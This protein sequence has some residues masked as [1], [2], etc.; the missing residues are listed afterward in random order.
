[1]FRQL[2]A[3]CLIVGAEARAVEA[4]RAL[5]HVLID[6]TADDLAVFED[7]GHFVAADFQNRA[8]A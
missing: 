6:Q 7:E 4:F 5:L 8:T 2:Q 3:L 1:M